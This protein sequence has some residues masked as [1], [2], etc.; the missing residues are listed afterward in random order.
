MKSKQPIKNQ[1]Q[2]SQIAYPKI[3][4]VLGSPGIQLLDPEVAP[5]LELGSPAVLLDG[6]IEVPFISVLAAD[7][8]DCVI[9]RQAPG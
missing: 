9:G 3:F 4:A 2:T 5:L 6:G 8:V 1:P 7:G